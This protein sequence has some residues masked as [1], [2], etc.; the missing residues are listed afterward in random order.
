MLNPGR[1]ARPLRANDLCSW[2]DADYLDFAKSS[3]EG[4]KR[5]NQAPSAFKT[6]PEVYEAALAKVGADFV[7]ASRLCCQPECIFSYTKPGERSRARRHSD[8]CF[9]CDPDVVSAGEST[10]VGIRK[11]AMDL[12]K[13]SSQPHVF[14]AARIKVS[15]EFLQDLRVC[16]VEAE[17]NAML[18]ED[19]VEQSFRGKYYLQYR[20]PSWRWRDEGTH[21]VITRRW[22][23]KRRFWE[24]GEDMGPD[25]KYG[26]REV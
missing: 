23:T 16:S 9:W 1:K 7:R 26:Q 2:C 8:L 3:I 14:E 17:R 10:P 24:C 25:A 4:R 13:F 5:L 19:V 15:A 21:M 6:H 20:E 22:S 11:I 18:K 12:R